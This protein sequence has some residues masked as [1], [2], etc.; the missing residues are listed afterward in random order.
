MKKRSSSAGHQR[1]S[2]PG[3]LRVRRAF[4]PALL[5]MMS[6]L[7]GCN[8]HY[9]W[10]GGDALPAPPKAAYA[11]VAEPAAYAEAV[12][13]AY[14]AGSQRSSSPL[15]PPAPDFNTEAYS[16]VYENSFRETLQ[17]PLS[18]FSI[19][20]DTASYA[21]VRRFLTGG[22]LP[23]PDAV[24]VEEMINYFG[25]DYPAPAGKEPFSFSTALSE[26]P[27]HPGHQLLLIGL[28]G[29][30]IPLEQL[31]PANLV[32]LIDVSGSMADDNKLPLL[33]KSFK[34]LVDELRPVDTVSIVV[35]AGQAGMVLPPTSGREK[36]KIV[37]A[38]DG[39]VA[40][41]ST[42]GG[43]GL[44]LAY[45]AA[46]KNFLPGGNNRIILATDGDFN[47][48]ASS[49][50]ELVRMIEEKRQEGVFLTVLGFGMGNFKDATMQKLADHGNGNY[51]YLDSLLEARKVLVSELGGTLFTIA[52]DVKLQVEF[53]PARV[54]A[55]RLIGYEK[56]L[57]SREDFADDGKDAGELGSG[58]T[59]TALYEIIPADGAPPVADGLIYQ[60][61]RVK[62][63]AARSPELATI[64]FRYQEPASQASREQAVTVPAT[65]LGLSRAGDNIR[66]AAAVAQWG[67]LLSGSKHK[68]SASFTAVLDLARQ[69]KGSDER[70]LRAE[71]IRL[72]ELSELIARVP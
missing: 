67:M 37:A 60:T 23:P 14:A 17:H 48:G 29:K 71:F 63:G 51:A 3:A 53:N 15:A 70:G 64:K 54:K 26:A 5:M 36:E 55:Y 41:G 59:V 34:L 12:A 9:F 21:N 58:H 1:E 30:K 50:G 8:G 2:A 7:T 69:S 11:S 44:K 65:L 35:Y 18:T 38:L 19:D 27:W 33:V 31:P 16:R 32:L 6:L 47:V 25:Y 46:K 39:L 4:A 62:E 24:R 68:G 40:D 43:E 49:E 57:L 45:A 13:V 66:F 42:A 72:V 61:S 22:S 28:Q 20:V 52:K 10:S 56:R